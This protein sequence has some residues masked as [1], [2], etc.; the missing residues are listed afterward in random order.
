L[1]RQQTDALIAQQQALALEKE[2]E[3]QS[4]EITTYTFAQIDTAI[5][6]ISNLADAKA[7]LRKLCRYIKARE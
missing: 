3:L 5:S 2:A 6:N 4:N 7:F 1:W